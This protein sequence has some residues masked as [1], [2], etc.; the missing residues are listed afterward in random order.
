[1][2]FFE[3]IKNLWIRYPERIKGIAKPNELENNNKMPLFK[4]YSVDAR[5]RIEPNI[6]PIQGVHPKANAMPIK[7]GL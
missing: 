3:N 1:M 7:T 4:L 6:G 5:T 2:K